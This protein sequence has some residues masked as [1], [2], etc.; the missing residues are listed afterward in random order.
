MNTPEVREGNVLIANFVAAT[1]V[2]KPEWEYT[3]WMI[4]GKSYREDELKYHSSWDWL[5]PVVEKI[6]TLFDNNIVVNIYDER[7]TI[8]VSTQYAMAKDFHLPNEFYNN[9]GPKIKSVWLSVTE[10][11]QWYNQNN[12][13]Q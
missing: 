1:N 11:L 2:G 12:Q 9:E 5:M 10:F 6:E 4:D 13:P 8:E 3:Y 7:C